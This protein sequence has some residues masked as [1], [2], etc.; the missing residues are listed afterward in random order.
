MNAT[1]SRVATPIGNLEDISARA[2]RMLAECDAVLCE[3]TRVTGK[4]LA[5]YDI[6]KSLISYHAHSGHAKYDKIFELLRERKHL[7]LVSDAG[8]PSISDP[9]AHLVE[10]VR[11]EFGND[12]R[13]ESIPGPSAVTAAL[14]LSGF[15]SDTFLFLGFP[16]H[17]KGRKT[18]FEKVAE[19]TYTTVFY[20]SPH[21]ILKAL[22]SL[23]EVLSEGRRIA[24]CRE[25]TKLF[26]ET[27]VGTPAEVLEHF[28]AH[29]DTVR[30]EFV[31]V[32]EALK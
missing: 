7:A 26:E 10:S 20:E 15:S 30:G 17:K 6:K 25:L 9:G 21:R 4:L 29:R 19:S 14:A 2:L 11:A 5:H 32:I 24:L 23:N 1:L 28:E 16:P 3:D 18:F 12:V 27:L 8:T 22:E 31:V 13:I